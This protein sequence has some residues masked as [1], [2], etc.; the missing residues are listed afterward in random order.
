[1]AW[2]NDHMKK[3]VVS[4]ALVD[5]ANKKWWLFEAT[6]D[7]KQQL[8]DFQTLTSGQ[9]DYLPSGIFVTHAHIGHYTG[10]MELG[11]EVMATSNVPVYALPKMAS[12]LTTN[13]PWSQ[14]VQQHNIALQPLTAESTITLSSSVSVKAFT[15]PHR[16]EYSETA[17]FKIITSAKK[18]LFIP[19][20]NKWE[21]WDRN[22][23]K[24]VEVVD[25]AFIDA[26][27]YSNTELPG[28]SMSEVPHPLVSETMQLF[29]NTP[30]ATRS[31]IWFIHFNHTNPLLWDKQKQAEVK[32]EGFNISVQG[33]QY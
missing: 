13:G 31:K 19:D 22:I 4:L 10:L 5:P 1:M 26:T 29:A 18:Y 2:K 17:G 16:D 11:K 28:R 3:N 15:V 7:I 9:Y 12:F 33:Q 25:N 6:P 30:A 24:E 32:K 21:K 23:I 8:H 27:F 14:L 20:I